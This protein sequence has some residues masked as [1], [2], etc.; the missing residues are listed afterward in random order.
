MTTW[1]MNWR[2]IGKKYKLKNLALKPTLSLQQKVSSTELF[3]AVVRM[4]REAKLIINDRG[5]YLSTL[6]FTY[7]Y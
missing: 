6:Y 7:Q 5:I 4:K 1:R 2:L 3:I